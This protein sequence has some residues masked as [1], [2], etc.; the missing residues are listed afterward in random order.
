MVMLGDANHEVRVAAAEALAVAG[1]RPAAERIFALFKKNERGVGTPLGT[2]APLA[3]VPA[4]SEVRGY[5]DDALLVDAL[6]A[7][8]LR[9]E[10]PDP[11]RVEIVQT[12]GQVP[13][14]AATGALVEFVASIDD[15]VRAGEQGSRRPEGSGA[16]SAEVLPSRRAA[17]NLIEQRGDL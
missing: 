1:H 16:P 9:P 10:A 11:L 12:L 4:V 5:I 8:L 13:G 2:L 6:A 3:Q 17:E 15:V 14:A 7:F